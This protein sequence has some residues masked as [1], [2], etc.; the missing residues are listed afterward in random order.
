[1]NKSVKYL[2]AAALMAI[3]ANSAEATLTVN[4]TKT[5][6]GANDVYIFRALSDGAAGGTRILGVNLE[7]SSDNLIK[8]EKVDADGDGEV[9][10]NIVGLS[11]FGFTN[12]AAPA[13]ATLAGSYVRLGTANTFIDLN[14][15]TPQGYTDGDGDGIPDA[16]PD[17]AGPQLD[18]KARQA[19][20]ATAK[21]FRVEGF[22]PPP[23]I[24]ATS[25][26]GIQIAGLI[27]PSGSKIG[28][29]YD[30]ADDGGTH[31]LGTGGDLIPEPGSLSILGIGA[32]GLLRRRRK[33]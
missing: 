7:L 21:K 6:V 24:V 20:Y 26:P 33:A 29:T 10:A 17:G 30:V 1:M 16:D 19:Y 2:A 27:V 15:N 28:Y 12:A 8:F 22:A 5:V 23:G 9:D 4:V 14:G 31:F 13:P 25:A 32:L 11:G 3:G 18:Y